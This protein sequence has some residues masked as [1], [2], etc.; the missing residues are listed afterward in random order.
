MNIHS[1]SIP[2]SCTAEHTKASHDTSLFFSQFYIPC[3]RDCYLI[4]PYISTVKVVWTISIYCFGLSYRVDSSCRISAILDYRAQLIPA[5]LVHKFVPGFG[6]VKRNTSHVTESQAII[7]FLSP[8]FHFL[9]QSIVINVPFISF[10]IC[11]PVVQVK[12]IVVSPV[13]NSALFHYQIA[14]CTSYI[15]LFISC[16]IVNR[17]LWESSCH[18]SSA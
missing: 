18:I 9:C 8:A 4:T 3:G 16:C 12:C 13:I 1:R 11:V 10:L 14:F 7:L 17:S 6:I 5:K 15:S 2:A